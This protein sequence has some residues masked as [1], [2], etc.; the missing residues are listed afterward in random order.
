MRNVFHLNT[1]IPYNLRPRSERYR[2][3]PRIVKY[4]A[5]T[6]S[7]LAPKMWSL[8]HNVIKNRKSLD[9]F[10]SEMRQFEPYCPCRLS[11]TYLQRVGFI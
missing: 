3:N 8:V 5:E 11:K 4:G 2:R 1:N 7:Y 6:I 9:T 10:K